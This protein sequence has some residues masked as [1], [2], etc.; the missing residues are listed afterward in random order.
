MSFIPDQ[1]LCG[2]KVWSVALEP[3]VR[4]TRWGINRRGTEKPCHV[5]EPA[6]MTACGV[7]SGISRGTI[8]IG[9]LVVLGP[10]DGAE[11]FL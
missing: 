5:R 4:M 1:H 9:Q 11:L 3:S 2:V 6:G 10:W 8:W 7:V